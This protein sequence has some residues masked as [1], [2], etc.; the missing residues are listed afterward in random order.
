[1]KAVLIE[2]VEYIKKPEPVEQPKNNIDATHWAILPDGSIL[3]YRVGD[4]VFLW[5]PS[6]KVWDS[7]ATVPYTLYVFCDDE[8]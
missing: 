4:K 1:M 8:M 5:K 2:G 6:S 3:F 7:P